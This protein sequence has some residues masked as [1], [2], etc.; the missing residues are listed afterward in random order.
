MLM[1]IITSASGRMTKLMGQE[2]TC[3]TTGPSMRV[4][5]VRILNM[6]RALRYGL[7]VHDLKDCTKMDT[8]TAKEVSA[9]SMGQ[10][11]KEI[12]KTQVSMAS[13]KTRGKTVGNTTESGKKGK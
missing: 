4:N 5:G 12:G 11:M 7:M 9:G 10:S 8:S 6:V 1:E 3:I 2:S 13:D